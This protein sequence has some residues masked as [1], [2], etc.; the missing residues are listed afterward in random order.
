MSQDTAITAVSQLSIILYWEWAEQWWAMVCSEGFW[1]RWK[2][3][4]YPR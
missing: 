2:Y 3:M 4:W 1:N